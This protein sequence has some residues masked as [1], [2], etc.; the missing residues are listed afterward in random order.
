MASTPARNQA[1]SCAVRDGRTLGE[2]DKTETSEVNFHPMKSHPVQKTICLLIGVSFVATTLTAF[3]A[4]EDTIKKDFQVKPGSKLVVAVDR[5]SI[6]VK[7]ADVDRVEIEVKRKLDR[8]GEAQAQDILH[9]HEVIISQEGDEVRVRAQFKVP[10]PTGKHQQLQVQYPIS[11]PK[12]F[13]LDLKTAGGSVGVGN[14]EGEVRAQTSAGNV[15]VAKIDGP[16]TAET[17]GGSVNV[18]ASSKTVTTKTSG[19]N[20]DIGET[21]SD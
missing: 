20:I 21:G 8:V 12:R 13:N 18:A 14:H 9:D 5:G 19:G 2:C 17:N 15:K 4:I 6:D 7:P 1:A 11:V 16:V 3:A 10:R